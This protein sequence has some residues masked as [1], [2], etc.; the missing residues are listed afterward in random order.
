MRVR[1]F[2][3]CD[4][5]GIAFTWSGR[6]FVPWEFQGADCYHLANQVRL[7]LGMPELPSYSHMTRRYRR[8]ELPCEYIVNEFRRSPRAVQIERLMNDGEIALVHGH[9]GTALATFV[10][11][12]LLAFGLDG[13]SHWFEVDDMDINSY[14]SVT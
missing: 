10:E 9:H 3:K 12:Q 13:R 6:C 5:V 8:M 1:I 14:W 7:A 11:G 2:D 4:Y